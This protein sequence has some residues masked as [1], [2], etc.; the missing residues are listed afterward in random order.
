MFDLC[1]YVGEDVPLKTFAYK[2]PVM[3]EGYNF[4]VCNF[5][6]LT[7]RLSAHDGKLSVEGGMQY[8]ALIVQDRTLLS[9]EALRK[10]EALSQA[11]I[12]VI[13]CDKGESVIDGLAKAHLRPDLT[14]TSGNQPDDRIC[15]FHRRTADTDIY[16]VYNHSN[17]TYDAPVTLRTSHTSAEAWSPQHT[18]RKP[19]AMDNDKQLQLHLEPYQ[20]IF[21]IIQ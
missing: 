3:S 4:D 21:I 15:F 10:I 11:G 18:T 2:L 6:A 17:R 19:L 8:S 13:R 16:F 12:P 9:P 5:D 20:S 14:M 7:N 1:V